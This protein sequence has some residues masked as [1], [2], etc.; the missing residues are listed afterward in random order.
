MSNAYEHPEFGHDAASKSAGY[1]QLDAAL[2]A[3]LAGE[4]DLIANL[5]NTSALLFTTLPQLNWAGFYLLHPASQG[6]ADGGLIAHVRPEKLHPGRHRL[7]MAVGEVI[8]HG[9]R[10]AGGQGLPD[11]MAADVAGTAHHEHVHDGR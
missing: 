7:G 6:G 2:A 1:A 4:H 5:A 3:L 9:H 10:M 11:A 8:E